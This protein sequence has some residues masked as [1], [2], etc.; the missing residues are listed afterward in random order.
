M[1]TTRTVTVVY[2]NH[3]KGGPEVEGSMVREAGERAERAADLIRQCGYRT[4][5]IVE[6][7]V[8]S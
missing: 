7:A 6:S 1:T 3:D 8:R 5:T 2:G 4:V